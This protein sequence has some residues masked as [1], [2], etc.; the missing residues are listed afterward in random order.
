MFRGG[1][2]G[3]RTRRRARRLEGRVAW[4]LG[5]PRSGSSW[6]TQMLGAHESIWPIHEPMIGWY[7]GP[8]VADLPGM[9]PAVISW[10]HCTVPRLQHA[11]P[12]QF[13][14]DEFKPTWLP[15][16][17]RLILERL[18]AEVARQSDGP[19]GA[20]A[21][22]VVKEP[23]GSQAADLI[24]EALPRSTLIFLLRDGRDV[25]DSQL[26]AL[27]KGSWAAPQAGSGFDSTEAEVRRTFLRDSAYKWLWRTEVV[28]AAYGR[29]PG[30]KHLLRYE[31]LLADPAPELKRILRLLA[32]PDAGSRT[33][34]IAAQY[35]F[36]HLP[37]DQ[38]G[39]LRFVRAAQ[40]GLWRE[41]LTADEQ[42]MVGQIL[43]TK[44]SE[45]GYDA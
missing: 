12:S 25:V 39:P 9:D 15:G 33:D 6:L 29:H 28:T 42:A 41:N 30:P 26:A 36:D 7:L 23:N 14:S 27:Q 1:G 16:L 17:R 24:L 31:D 35:A 32:L 43:G 18:E 45:L 22:V 11:T 19:F 37:A 13:F 4:I 38:K 20:P 21:A 2:M 8:F 10:E 44:L 34:A 5:S 40:P 3:F